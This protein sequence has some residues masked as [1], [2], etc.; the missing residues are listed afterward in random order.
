MQNT[1]QESDREAVVKQPVQ[2]HVD[3]AGT[4]NISG[5]IRVFDPNTNETLVESRE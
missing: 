2:P 5:Y 4:V 1:K 3:E